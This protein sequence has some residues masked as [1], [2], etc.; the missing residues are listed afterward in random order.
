MSIKKQY[1]KSKP[2]CKVTFCLPKEAA[3]S[4]TQVNIVGEFNDWDVRATPM[5]KLKNGNF[6]V[7]LDLE[8]GREYQYRYLIDEKYWE[9][10]WC[11]DNYVRAP[12]GN[13]DNS[14]VI[15]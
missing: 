2:V 3:R 9:N 5:K 11:A 1:L 8:A 4:A 6:T 12:F 10:D 15:V 13:S 7:T 14:V